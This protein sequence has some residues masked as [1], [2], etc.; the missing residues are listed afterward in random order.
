MLKQILLVASLLVAHQYLTT[1][2]QAQVGEPIHDYVWT[3]LN[4]GVWHGA[5]NWSPNGVPGGD[6][7][8]ADSV[9]ITN[10]GTYTVELSDGVPRYLTN[11]VVGGASSGTQTLRLASGPLTVR[12]ALE[13]R[14]G[15]VLSNN[16]TLFMNGTISVATNGLCCLNSSQ[17]G[18]VMTGTNTVSGPLLWLSG[19]IRG[20]MEVT[21]NG[22]LT[23]DSENSKYLSGTL[24]NQGQVRWRN[25]Y[26]FG[27]NGE[28][29]LFL[30]ETNGLFEILGDNYLIN[31]S[32]TAPRLENRGVIRK[33]GGPGTTTVS[34]SITNIPGARIESLAG[35]LRLDRGGDFSGAHFAPTAPG[36]IYFGSGTVAMDYYTVNEGAGILGISGYV[37]LE[38]AVTLTNLLVTGNGTIL[39]T[40]LFHQGSSVILAAQGGLGDAA[41]HISFDGD[42][43][44]QRGVINGQICFGAPSHISLES[45]GGHYWYANVTNYGAITWTNASSITFYGRLENESCGVLDIRN[46]S[47]WSDNGSGNLAGLSRIVNRGVIRKRGD[48]G[49][50][51][52][53]VPFDNFGEVLV[54]AGQLQFRGGANGLVG[55]TWTGSSQVSAGA[56]LQLAGGP[57]TLT[58]SVQIEGA[59]LLRLMYGVEL[60]G[61]LSATNCLVANGILKGTNTLAGQVTL[62][63]G[64]ELAGKSLLTGT[65]IAAGGAASGELTVAT[66]GLLLIDGGT[67]SG[68]LTNHG[69]IHWRSNSLALGGGGACLH[70]AAD[71]TFDIEC[72]ASVS[73][74]SGNTNGWL[75]FGQ[76]RKTAGTGQS[77]INPAFI[78]AGRMEIQRGTL[79]FAALTL[80]T[81]SSLVFPLG[82]PVVGQDYGCLKSYALDLLGT[83][84]YPFTNG[85]TPAL[86][87]RFTN[88]V[89]NSGASLTNHLACSNR[90][91]YATNRYFSLA[92]ASSQTY[93]PND[94][95]VATAHSVPVAQ[96]ISVTLPEDGE[97][98]VNVGPYCSNEDGGLLQLTE[99][100]FSCQHG[101]TGLPYDEPVQIMNQHTHYIPFW[102]YFGPDQFTYVVTDQ[103][104]VTASNL[105]SI[106]VTAVDDPPLADITD[107]WFT[108]GRRRSFQIAAV[109]PDSTNTVTFSLG[110]GAPGGAV[111]SPDGWFAWQPP[112][113]A[114]N[115]TNLIQVITTDG[116][117][118]G[119]N[120]F[121][122]YVQAPQPTSL[123]F[124]T[125]GLGQWQM[126]IAGEPELDHILQMSTNL[127]DW[128]NVRTNS[129]AVTPYTVTLPDTPG[130]DR[131]FYRLLLGP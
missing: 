63:G 75:N 116:A 86:L 37:T 102:N 21:T 114:Q 95:L 117:A 105:V 87:Q 99:V 53:G 108:A 121:T 111:I 64:G 39:G 44:W 120:T 60:T 31:N 42:L 83:I 131:A 4:G 36:A 89:G 72:D 46:S 103:Q 32:A 7:H 48:T 47:W 127:V 16:V 43:I 94:T 51:Y 11:L 84:D 85:Y 20:R 59:G 113:A 81:N 26:Y 104:G 65:L 98:V 35:I 10:A 34:V 17:F 38:G 61:T 77:T 40:N 106:T 28:T 78:N 82:G 119:T 55:G 97:A 68:M 18:D 91:F 122:A 80:A 71:G 49:T 107:K 12:Q 8:V 50:T 124:Q 25:G 1:N 9:W 15:G 27:F 13:V 123:S 19:I 90:L 30:N 3:N 54:Q 128:Q 52:F 2:A 14:G 101:S 126:Q 67:L 6:L 76:L 56:E 130:L 79:S 110:A 69:S 109:D 57:V 93:F 41:S 129:R 92:L 29:P 118:T 58:D 115:T 96:P 33:S 45:E 24:A 70:N 62:A 112:V 73:V 74:G 23:L 5:T 88:V 100:H 66:N 22:I 125:N